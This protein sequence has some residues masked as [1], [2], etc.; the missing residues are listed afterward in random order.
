MRINRPRLLV[1]SLAVAVVVSAVG[2]YVWSQTV[3]DG[4]PAPDAVL[5]DPRDRTIPDEVAGIPTNIDM[6][7]DLLPSAIVLDP[8]GNEVST[9]SFLGEPLVINFWFSTCIPCEKEL[10]DFAEVDA[11]VGDDVRFIGINTT[12]SVP[13]MERFARERGVNYDLY[14]DSFAEFIEGARVVAFPYTLF[15]T[16]AGEIVDQTGVIDADGLRAK[17]ANLQE[18]DAR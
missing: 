17:V 9:D 6:E 12:D 11:E 4:P 3:A 13:V 16:S 14:Q 15:V 18:M 5:D 2:G 7:G 10:P 1:G 8:E